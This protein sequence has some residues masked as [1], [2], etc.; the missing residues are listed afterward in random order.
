MSKFALVGEQDVAVNTQAATVATPSAQVAQA[1]NILLLSLAVVSKRFVTALS[2]LF[3]AAALLSA[4]FLWSRILPNP[5]INQIAGASL[6]S[7]FVL[8]VDYVRRR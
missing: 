4:W 1:T 8:A 5:S 3:T 7:I 2:H 6:Y